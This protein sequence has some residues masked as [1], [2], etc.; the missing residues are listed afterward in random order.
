MKKQGFTIIELMIVLAIVGVMSAM[1][2]PILLDYLLRSKVAEAMSLLSGT[3]GMLMEYYQ[4]R[5]VWP[6]LTVLQAKTMGNYVQ[7]VFTGGTYPAFYVEAVMKAEGLGKANGC[8]VRII[9][10][11][12]ERSWRCTTEGTAR[13]L[14]AN[15]LPTSCR[16]SF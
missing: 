13:P 10:H 14:P 1:S 9:F 8:A 11:L 7:Q 2:V 6:A 4:D 5:N 15:L 16:D 3:K 12:P